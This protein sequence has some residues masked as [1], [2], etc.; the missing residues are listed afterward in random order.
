ME[1]QISNLGRKLG[2]LF[3]PEIHKKFLKTVT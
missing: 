3:F 1:I 2:K